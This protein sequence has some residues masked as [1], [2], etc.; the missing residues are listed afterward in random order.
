MGMTAVPVGANF[1]AVGHRAF[2]LAA[3][4]RIQSTGLTGTIQNPTSHV[5]SL[6]TPPPPLR[7]NGL[8]ADDKVSHASVDSVSKKA[9][10]ASGKSLPVILP[11]EPELDIPQVNHKKA[12]GLAEAL[13][14][15]VD[16][17]HRIQPS[18]MLDLLRLW[19]F[20]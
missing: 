7:K 18:D 8:V 15:R 11:R 16:A 17:G 1:S 20:K 5:P 3:E 14:A 10:P 13:L 9:L 12:E 2:S 4:L 6:P 19:K